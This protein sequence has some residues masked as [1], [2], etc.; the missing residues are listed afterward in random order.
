MALEMY[1]RRN[2]NEKG[3][4]GSKLGEVAY[5]EIGAVLHTRRTIS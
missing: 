3:G 5:D 2:S 1:L 4:S